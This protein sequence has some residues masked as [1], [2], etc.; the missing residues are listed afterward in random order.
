MEPMAPPQDISRLRSINREPAGQV[1]SQIVENT[2][3]Y[4]ENLYR[5][6]PFEYPNYLQNGG[7][8]LRQYF[9][10]LEG[11]LN[12]IASAEQMHISQKFPH[13]SR[14]ETQAPSLIGE[15]SQRVAGEL[16][17]AK[18]LGE[19]TLS[20]LAK[21]RERLAL[22]RDQLQGT[23]Q[24]VTGKL[25]HI[26]EKVAE[27]DDIASGARASSAEIGA[28]AQ[29]GFF[30]SEA[31]SHSKAA[32]R[33]L[34]SAVVFGSIIIFIGFMIANG[35]L[36]PSPPQGDTAALANYITAKV[37][38]L[39][40]LSFGLAF[41]ARNYGSH[42]HNATLNRHRT[43]ALQTFRSLAAAAKGEEARDII[44]KEAAAAIFG[45]HDTGYSKSVGPEATQI[46]QVLPSV[47]RQTHG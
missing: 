35:A 47:I 30:N 46:T 8:S 10:Q 3:S 45:V 34:G 15:W 41:S 38:I 2:L 5:S 20:L 7:A 19:G 37:L 13:L 27:I 4:I 21:E 32:E 36:F 40:A 16:L 23:I 28:A 6:I 18:L 11:F 14:L 33:W 43:N 44:L 22:E 17:P 29:A 24:E 9:T 31:A 26:N 25:E 42:R 39:A 12:E 1:Y